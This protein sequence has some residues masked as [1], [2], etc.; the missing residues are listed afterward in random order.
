MLAELLFKKLTNSDNQTFKKAFFLF[1]K[2]HGQ[3]SLKK[4]SQMLEHLEICPT[5]R[6]KKIV[7]TENSIF[8]G[9]EHNLHT[10]C[11]SGIQYRTALH[12]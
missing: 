5:G 2:T 7:M 6:C 10:D 8:I 9:D 4:A 3:I 11:I 12:L 1:T